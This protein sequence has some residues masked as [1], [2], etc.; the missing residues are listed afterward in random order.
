MPKPLPSASDLWEWLEFNPLTGCL[1]WRKSPCSAL[2]KG[3]QAGSMGTH[4]LYAGVL[5]NRYAVHRLV[6][7]WCTGNEPS[8]CI[9]HL[10]DNKTN[11]QFWNLLSSSQRANVHRMHSEVKGYQFVPKTG[12]YQAIIG[13]DGKHIALGTFTTPQEAHS[14]YLQALST[15]DISPPHSH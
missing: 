11:N 9:E 7:K 14:A 15:Y 8:N 5:G 1:Y 6:Y 10:D 3:K 13:V 4:Y 12:K 2:P